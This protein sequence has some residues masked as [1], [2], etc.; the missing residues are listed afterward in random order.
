MRDD[1]PGSGNQ[2]ITKGNS[3]R[4]VDTGALV[5]DTQYLMG[6]EALWIAGPVSFQAEYGWQWVDNVLGKASFNAN[7]SL[8]TPFATPQNY[9]FS[10]GYVQA[11]YALTGENRAYDKAGGTIARAYYGKEG[12]Y[13]RAW[14]VRDEDGGICSSWGAWEVAGRYSYLNLNDGSGTYLIQ[15]GIMQGVGLALNW[16]LNNNLTINFDWNYDYRDDVPSTKATGSTSGF[17]SRVQFQ[18]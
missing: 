15:G 17:G 6:L 14:W 13:R 9:L 7:G 18:F 4:M 11:T 8:V 10:G 16:Y 2:A 1:T 5:S 3:N 12:P